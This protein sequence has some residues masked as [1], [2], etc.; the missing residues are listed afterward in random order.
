MS[1]EN[2]PNFHACKFTA[3]VISSMYESLRGNATKE[4]I[5]ENL[6][7]LVVEFVCKVE[8]VIDNNVEATKAAYTDISP[9]PPSQTWK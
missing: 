7:K 9:K 4:D 5:P 3:D 6:D 8:Q 2:H 1:I